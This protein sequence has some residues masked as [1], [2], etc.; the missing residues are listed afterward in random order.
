MTKEEQSKWRV[1]WWAKRRSAMEKEL[2]GKRFGRWEVLAWA[3]KGTHKKGAT[4]KHPELKVRCD[5]GTISLIPKFRLEYGYSKS[6][7]CSQVRDLSGRV[8]GNLTVID[9]NKRFKNENGRNMVKLQC[10]CGEVVYRFAGSLKGKK[11]SCGCLRGKT[12]TFDGKTMSQKRWADSLGLSRQ[13]LHSRLKT[14]PIEVALSPH[15]KDMV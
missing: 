8:F 5:C 4:V 14:H 3:S 12:I 15:F 9:G 2:I 11:L 10:V 7:G 13:T 1:E 6:C